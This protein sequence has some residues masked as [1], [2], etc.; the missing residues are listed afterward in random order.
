[1]S[2]E[3][4]VSQ[5]KLPYLLLTDPNSLVRKAYGVRKS[6]GFLPGRATFVIDKEG[7]IRHAFSSQMNT[8]QHVDEALTALRKI[9]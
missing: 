8:E 7:T 2:H 1:A 9:T 5:Y 6:L 4:F 3:K